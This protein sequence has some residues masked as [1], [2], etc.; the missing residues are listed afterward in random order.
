MYLFRH[1]EAPSPWAPACL[2]GRGRSP[3]RAL[4]RRRVARGRTARRTRRNAEGNFRRVL[5]IQNTSLGVHHF[6]KYDPDESHT[7]LCL[8]IALAT[9]CRISQATQTLSL[10]R[11]G[12][13]VQCSSKISVFATL[14]ITVLIAG[15]RQHPPR[16][17]FSG[18]G[19]VRGC[20][21]AQCRGRQ[22]GGGDK[23]RRFARKAGHGQ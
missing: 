15:T 21:A 20:Q 22:L 14:I 12:Q 6:E 17:L 16:G 7:A 9:A 4:K 18:Q 1:P 23:Q 11:A 10:L 2:G 19:Y 5:R 8:R 13:S 3:K